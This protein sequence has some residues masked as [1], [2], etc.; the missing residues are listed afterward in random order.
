MDT[1]GIQAVYRSREDERQFQRASGTSSI[2]RFE[3]IRHSV[4]EP[5]NKVLRPE[6]TVA[7]FQ[8]MEAYDREHVVRLDLN[9]AHEILGYETVGVGTDN[10][11]LVGPKEVFRGALL[12]GASSIIVV[13]NHPSGQTMPSREDHEVAR[14]LHSLGALLDLQ[15]LDFLIIGRGRRYYSFAEQDLM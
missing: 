8:F 1:G 9:G 3:I 5:G 13:H 2:Y 12:A 6:D 7:Y 11:S 15:V 10:M 14:K 4:H